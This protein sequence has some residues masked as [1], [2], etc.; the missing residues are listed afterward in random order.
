M[1]L[2][3]YAT[4]DGAQRVAAQ[5]DPD[6]LL[7]LQA[8]AERLTGQCA[9]HFN[10][11]QS[12]I[13]S[14][15]RGL[16]S[17]RTMIEAAPDA[18]RLKLEGLSLLSPLPTPT[19]LRDGGFFLEHNEIIAEYM[20][21]LSVAKAPDPEAAFEE[22]RKSGKLKLPEVF[23]RRLLYYPGNHHSVIGHNQP[24]K[25]PSDIE[26]IDYELELAVVVGC[27]GANLTAE[28]MPEHI[29]GYTLFND[30]SARDLQAELIP[31]FVGTAMGKEFANSL[32]P[33]IVT[34]DE[35]ADPHAL[36][37]TCSVDGEVWSRGW[38]KNMY[39]SFYSGLALA[40]RITPLV[41][42]EVMGS[43]TPAHGSAMEQGKKLV[44]GQTVSL[45]CDQI[46]TLSNRIEA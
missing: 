10:S 13:E 33:C 43:G 26:V 35:I 40:S 17:A 44:P 45:H 30:W 38:T 2:Y 6:T 46:G 37:L 34:R 16:D 7:D 29:F 20:G 14:G 41:A 31:T 21:R 23:Y 4:A 24:L 1:K 36:E 22:L 19:K 11:M 15:D 5:I 9:P 42:G 28:E 18:C 25:W 39:H 8:A 12:L 27:G 32:G 3:T